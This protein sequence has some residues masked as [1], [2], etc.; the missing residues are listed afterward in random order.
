[1]DNNRLA[2]MIAQNIQQ[3]VIGNDGQVSL[4]EKAYINK[5]REHLLELRENKFTFKERMEKFFKSQ[6]IDREELIEEIKNA[7]PKFLK[8]LLIEIYSPNQTDEGRKKTKR[9]RKKKNPKNKPKKTRRGKKFK[10]KKRKRGKKRTRR[11]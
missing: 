7:D 2:Q 3:G 9:K 4:P 8:D 11:K 1:M 6:E 10:S 5:I